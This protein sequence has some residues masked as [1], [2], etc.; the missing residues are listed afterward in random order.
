MFRD[1]RSSEFWESVACTCTSD[2]TVMKTCI[3]VL[4][5][6]EFKVTFLRILK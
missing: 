4:I 3:M 6:G 2:V 1:G 5:V